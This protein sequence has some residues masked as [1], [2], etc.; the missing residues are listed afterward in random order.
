[1][2]VEYARYRI[3]HDRREAFVE[4]YEQAATY[5][6]ASTHCLSYELSHCVE[7]QDRYILRIEWYSTQEHLE[8]FRKEPGF[9]EF[10]R[11]VQPFLHEVE[12][13]Q[14][15]ELTEVVDWKS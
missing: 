1:M 15:Y 9:R 14:H 11:L 4:A 8:G 3:S 2:I 7:E 12:E 6:T 13:M 5:L 10:F